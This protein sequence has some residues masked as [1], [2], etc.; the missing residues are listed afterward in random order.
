MSVCSHNGCI[1]PDTVA[2]EG[3]WESG[4]VNIWQPVKIDPPQSHQH[5]RWGHCG[6]ECS[7]CV[8][9]VGSWCTAQLP[10][11]A[12]ASK[13][14]C[15]QVWNIAFM[16]SGTPQNGSPRCVVVP[17]CLLYVQTQDRPCS[18]S[19]KSGFMAD[20]ISN[21]K[22]WVQ[23]CCLEGGYSRFIQTCSIDA[24]KKSSFCSFCNIHVRPRTS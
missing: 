1:N 5:R 15:P 18:P 4:L 9:T 10:M 23:T 19:Q 3:E 20:G 21:G 8:H 2:G 24:K 12:T 22:A 13:M 11:S 14:Q 16:P 6:M 7:V 17:H